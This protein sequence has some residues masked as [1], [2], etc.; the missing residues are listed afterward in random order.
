MERIAK[1]GKKTAQ[2]AD[3]K[4]VDCLS[5]D[6]IKSDKVSP[7]VH[8]QDVM[9]ATQFT[10]AQLASAFALRVNMHASALPYWHSRIETLTYQG[11]SADN[12]L[13]LCTVEFVTHLIKR[14]LTGARDKRQSKGGNPNAGGLAVPA[15]LTWRQVMDCLVAQSG[16]A[17]KGN[18]Q[19]IKISETDEAEMRGTVALVLTARGTFERTLS[20]EDIGE[21][22]RLVESRKCLDLNRRWKACEDSEATLATLSQPTY[23]ASEERARI[24]ALSARLEQIE[25]CISAAF[26]ADTS[27]QAKHKRKTALRICAEIVTRTQSGSGKDKSCQRKERAGFAEYIKRGAIALQAD[28]LAS[29]P[30]QF[31]LVTALDSLALA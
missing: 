8:S 1:R 19:P 11:E 12:S 16:T 7:L 17:K 13:A 22:F 27:K 29:A 2:S 15:G 9:N 23:D 10:L 30:W 25:A 31:D 4:T 20:S 14:S 6:P 21:C 28:R 5:C 3:K 24:A 18:R 26:K